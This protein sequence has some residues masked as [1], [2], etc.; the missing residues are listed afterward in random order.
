VPL[1][2]NVEVVSD[3]NYTVVTV[4]SPKVEEE[5]VVEEEEEGL[6]EGEEGAEGEAAETDAEPEKKKNSAAT[7]CLQIDLDWLSDSGIRGITMKI[8]GIMPASW[9]PTNLPGILA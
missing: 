4:L 1:G 3:V 8:P 2:D 7:L 6:E 9:S 5:E